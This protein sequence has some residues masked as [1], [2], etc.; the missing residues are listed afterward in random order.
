MNYQD[1]VTLTYQRLLAIDWQPND[2]DIASHITLMQEYLRRSS[3][4]AEALNCTDQ[5]PFFDVANRIEP[6]ARANS[7]IVDKLL[8]HLSQFKLPHRIKKTCE[9][10]LNW[11]I[12]SNTEQVS[13]FILDAP[14]EPLLVMYEHGGRFTTEHGFVDIAGAG[15]PIGTWNNYVEM[16]PLVVLDRKLPE[17]TIQD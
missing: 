13:K 4:W 7:L 9:W 14:Y 6:S 10:S 17:L 12:I 16:S 3:L 5:W 15:F 8:N 11:A 1:P 2:S